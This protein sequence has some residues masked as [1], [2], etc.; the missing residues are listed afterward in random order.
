MDNTE[1]KNEALIGGSEL[2]DGLGA[3]ISVLDRLP[4]PDAEVLWYSARSKSIF[5]NCLRHGVTGPYGENLLPD[6]PYWMPLPKAP[7][8]QGEALP[9]AERGTKL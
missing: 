7:N 5:I 2:N 1:S 6:I 9:T 3:W 4:H 8:L